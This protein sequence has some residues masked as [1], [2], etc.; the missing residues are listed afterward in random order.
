MTLSEDHGRLRATLADLASYLDLFESWSRVRHR[1]VLPSCQLGYLRRPP[2]SR[3]RRRPAIPLLQLLVDPDWSVDFADPQVGFGGL[4]RAPAH[5]RIL[6]LWADNLLSVQHGDEWI[7]VV[8][9][10]DAFTEEWLQLLRP[11]N[12]SA[13]P[14]YAV[15]TAAFDGPAP[16][17]EFD[18]AELERVTYTSLVRIRDRRRGGGVS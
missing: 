10:E 12:G 14:P 15:V 2:A 7:Y 16:I 8:D 18:L 13:A 1:E 6:T 5:N 9:S 17:G 11:S 3:G 4:T